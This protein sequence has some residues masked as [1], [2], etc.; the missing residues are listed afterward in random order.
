MRMA[1]SA[2]GSLDAI[3]MMEPILMSHRVFGQVTKGAQ[4]ARNEVKTFI[5]TCINVSRYDGKPA[6]RAISI[7]V[8]TDH[9]RVRPLS[10]EHDVCILS[11][12]PEPN[13]AP[14]IINIQYFD[15]EFK[16]L[17]DYVPMPKLTTRGEPTTATFVRT[18]EFSETMATTE[19]KL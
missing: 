9:C 2:N 7:T 11:M 13:V 4:D 15:R 10:I 16:F 14:E 17:M 12:L 8:E 19:R 1:I 18:P 6:N 3:E 5:E